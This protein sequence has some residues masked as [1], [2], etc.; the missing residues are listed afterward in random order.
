MIAHSLALSAL[1]LISRVEAA[2]IARVFNVPVEAAWPAAVT[3]ATEAFL[4]DRISHADHRLRLRA[5]PLRAY[6]FEISVREAGA[7]KTRVEL[8]L[9]TPTAIPAVR[10]EAQR[11]ADRYFT[12]LRQRLE[13]PER[14]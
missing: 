2:E 13:K 4:A 3:V 12:L 8:T 11:N 6:S 14:K 9:R 1:F 10:Q 7:G 5:G